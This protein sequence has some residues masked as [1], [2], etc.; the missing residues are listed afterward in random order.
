M[1]VLIFSIEIIELKYKSK[2]ESFTLFN[3]NKPLV[4]LTHPLHLGA[5]QENVVYLFDKSFNLNCSS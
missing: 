5:N 2:T 3:K 4:N 1:P